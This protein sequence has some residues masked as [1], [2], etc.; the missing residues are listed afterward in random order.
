MGVPGWSKLWWRVGAGAAGGDLQPGELTHPL[1]CFVWSWGTCMTYWSGLTTQ[2]WRLSARRSPRWMWRAWHWLHRWS[3]HWDRW[4]T[5]T[6]ECW[7]P[8]GALSWGRGGIIICLSPPSE[9]WSLL[10]EHHRHVW[11]RKPIYVGVCGH[12][13]LAFSLFALGGTEPQE[14][15]VR[16]SCFPTLLSCHA[17]PWVSLSWGWA[18]ISVGGSQL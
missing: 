17:G 5:V 8:L 14:R 15:K 3:R 1:L 11:A 10:Q 7:S 13:F 2:N 12:S 6:A 18:L 16:V 9:Q 4:H